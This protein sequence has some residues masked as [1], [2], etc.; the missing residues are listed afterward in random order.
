MCAVD[1]GHMLAELAALGC[2]CPAVTAEL[3]PHGPGVVE[4]H[5][6]HHDDCPAIAA[7]AAAR[8]PKGVG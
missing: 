6:A 2:T 3:I 1:I 8:R 7:A 5:Y 4:V